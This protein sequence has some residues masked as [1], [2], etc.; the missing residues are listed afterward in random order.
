MRLGQPATATLIALLQRTPVLRV[1]STAGDYVLASPGGIA[2]KSI[3]A[4]AA[5]LG[6]IDSIAGATT[7]ASTLTPNPTGTLPPLEAT[8]GVAIAPVGFTIT[9]TMNIGSWAVSGQIP[10]VWSSP[11]SSRMGLAHWTW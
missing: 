4:A 6:A 1:V 7:L 11:R 9:N 8:V 3:A 5:S 2:L 10:P